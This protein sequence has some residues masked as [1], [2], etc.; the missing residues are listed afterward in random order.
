[1]HSEDQ[2]SLT[3]FQFWCIIHFPLHIFYNFSVNELYLVL[4]IKLRS[5]LAIKYQ[6]KEFYRNVKIYSY[7]FCLF[8]NLFNFNNRHY[9]LIVLRLSQKRSLFSKPFLFCLILTLNEHL[10]FSWYNNILYHCANFILLTS[11]N[12]ISKLIISRRFR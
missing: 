3:F 12:F 5:V 8:E 11:K 6:L 9:L 2:T 7:E 1:M 4:V 10:I